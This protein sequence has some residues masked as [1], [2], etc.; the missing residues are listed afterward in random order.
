[1][2]HSERDTAREVRER[3]EREWGRIEVKRRARRQGAL[4]A[5]ASCFVL[6]LPSL[7][8]YWETMCPAGHV[9]GPSSLGN[10]VLYNI[11]CII[12]FILWIV[13]L[14]QQKRELQEALEKAEEAV[15]ELRLARL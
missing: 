8:L 14:R 7:W 6:S 9:C 3:A 10:A 12:G 5:A 2:Q 13:G 1:M 11:V 4:W 15:N